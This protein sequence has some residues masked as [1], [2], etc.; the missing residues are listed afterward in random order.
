VLPWRQRATYITLKKMGK[1]KS[2]FPSGMVYIYPYLYCVYKYPFHAHTH[3]QTH[4]ELFIIYFSS[5]RVSN[6]NRWC[7]LQLGRV[8]VCASYTDTSVRV[9]V[10]EQMEMIH[11]LNSGTATLAHS[12]QHKERKKGMEEPPP[13]CILGWN[14]YT[15]AV[16]MVMTSFL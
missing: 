12:T 13:P 5:F 2:F 9:C 8:C 6:V 4:A 11:R 7:Q 16:V 10:C 1:S 3:T 14:V 15:G